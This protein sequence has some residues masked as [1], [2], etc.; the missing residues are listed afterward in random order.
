MIKQV[1]T[2]I[3]VRLLTTNKTNIFNDYTIENKICINIVNFL[4][5]LPVVIIIMK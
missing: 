5:I 1:N 4:I 3:L 2:K